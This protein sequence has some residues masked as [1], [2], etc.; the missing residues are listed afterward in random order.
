MFLHIRRDGL[1]DR[2]AKHTCVSFLTP[3]KV[4]QTQELGEEDMHEGSVLPLL[5]HPAWIWCS[6]WWMLLEVSCDRVWTPTTDQ[7]I[8]WKVFHIA[9][10]FW[11]HFIHFSMICFRS[12]K[13][14]HMSGNMRHREG[15]GRFSSVS[16]GATSRCC[17]NEFSK[18]M[19]Y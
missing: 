6:S 8:F 10:I 18:C 9:P 14:Q 3:L 16:L 1:T 19:Y 2:H 5:R 15:G 7:G 12:A 17:W 4:W 11:I 13:L